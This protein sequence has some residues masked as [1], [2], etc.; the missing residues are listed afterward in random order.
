MR[1]L[2]QI[3]LENLYKRIL[4][5]NNTDKQYEDAVRDG[6]LKTA[7]S[8]VD[9]AAKAAGYNV[10][11]VWHYG[12]KG[13]TEFRPFAREFMS[14]DKTAEQV[15]AFIRRAKERQMIGTMDFR[16]GTFFTPQRKS[17]SS[18]GPQEYG[19]YLKVENAAKLI[20][21]DQWKTEVPGKPFDA[22]MM[23]MDGDGVVK[24]IAIIDPSKIKSA[25]PITYDDSKNII[26]ISKRFDSSNNDI[27]Y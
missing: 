5:E 20:N 24:E 9:K 23:D 22:I 4:L 7:Q 15:D 18:Y 12:A 3:L 19:V 6:D 16:A 11:P 26:P 2:D 1:S 21:G 14:G 8:M 10:G 13:I 17:Y 25:N 27:R